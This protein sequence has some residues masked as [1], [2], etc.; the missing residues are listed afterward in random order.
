MRKRPM[1]ACPAYTTLILAAMF[2]RRC[3]RGLVR[4]AGRVARQR[5]LVLS[6][7][8]LSLAWFAAPAG[9]IVNGA[10]AS[11]EIFSRRFAWAVALVDPNSGGVC[12]A[13]LVSPTWV[14]TAAHCASTDMQARVGNASRSRAR[15]LAVVQAIRHPQFDPASGQYDVGLLRLAQPAGQPAVRL[16]DATEAAAMLREGAKVIIAGWG[17]R[18]TRGGFSERLVVS[19]VELRGLERDGSRF[20]YADPVSGPCSGDSGGPLL[21]ERPDGPLV[22]VGI[23]SRVIGD[24]CAQ[25]GGIGIYVDVSRVRDFI[26]RHVADLRLER[27]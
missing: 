3:D 12:S 14:L 26:A 1:L 25:G 6:A 9:A 24:I 20:G 11:D 21:V 17:Y 7:L 8:A 18:S 13:A 10:A 22:L 2:A 4:R 19:D 23:A 5:G 15:T 27:L 16:A